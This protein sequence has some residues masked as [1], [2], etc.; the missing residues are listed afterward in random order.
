[1]AAILVDS[2][3]A[4]A[5]IKRCPT[6]S[7]YGKIDVDLFY[8]LKIR[9]FFIHL[10]LEIAYEIPVSNPATNSNLGLLYSI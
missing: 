5:A 9:V 10:K 6:A 4:G 8:I 2:F 3:S 7:S 1:M